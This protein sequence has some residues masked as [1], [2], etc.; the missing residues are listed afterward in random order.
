MQSMQSWTIFYQPWTDGEEED[1]NS[2][3]S[4]DFEETKAEKY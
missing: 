4:A 2:N 1:I 3:T